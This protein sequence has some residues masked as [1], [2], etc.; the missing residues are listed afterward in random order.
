M[1]GRELLADGLGSRLGLA[2]VPGGEEDERE[3]LSPAQRAGTSLARRLRC[4]LPRRLRGRQAGPD[5][6][7]ER[8]GLHRGASVYVGKDC[9]V[10]DE[11]RRRRRA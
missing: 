4:G 6:A 2:Q 7:R 9:L 3:D 10:I 11:P 1:P 5:P 8:L